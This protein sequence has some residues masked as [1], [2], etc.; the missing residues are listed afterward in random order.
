[1]N[2]KNNIRSQ[3]TRERIKHALLQILERQDILDVTVSQLCK[4]ADINRSTFYSHYDSIA[5]TMEELELEIGRNVL[6]SFSQEPSTQSNPFSMGHLTQILLHIQENK[7][8]YRVYL[9]QSTSQGKLNWAFGQLLER[10]FRPMMRKLS[11]DD[12]AIEYYFSFFRAGLMAV[13]TRWVQN[14]CQEEPK[15]I[16][17]YLQNLLSHPEF[18]L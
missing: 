4:V 10:F 8:F 6:E 1:M 12:D 3:E 14:R 11:V 15:V 9:T 16:A 13:I 17:S 18:T 7:N 2:T 5:D